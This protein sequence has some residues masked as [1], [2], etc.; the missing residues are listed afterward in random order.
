MT[1]PAEIADALAAGLAAAAAERDAEQS[2]FGIDALAETQ[3][4]P[5]LAAGLAAAGMG[6]R[7][8]QRYPAERARR[9]RSVGERCDLVATPDGRALCAPDDAP[10][11]FAPADAAPL[12]E[13]CWIEVKTARVFHADG[14]NGRYAAELLGAPSEDVVRLMT[15]EGI[16]H[17][18]LALVLFAR[19]EADAR[20][21]IGALERTLRAE[22]LPVE[23]PRVRLVPIADRIGHAIAAVALFPVGRV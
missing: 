10:D 2:A 11:L 15:A 22:G 4:H 7:T 20:R 23:V 12:D 19:A 9:R 1:G 8:E 14:P 13:A 16:R 5:V 21:D 18:H 17:A 3:L 6:V